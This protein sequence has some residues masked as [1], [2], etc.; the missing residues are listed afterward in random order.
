[1]LRQGKSGQQNLVDVPADVVG[2]D[3]AGDDEL[4]G[5]VDLQSSDL[6]GG[7]IVDQLPSA[8]LEVGQC[9]VY[10]IEKFLKIRN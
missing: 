3:L 8:V 4:L 10:S 7:Y 9:D 1:M 2:A 5:E 6:V